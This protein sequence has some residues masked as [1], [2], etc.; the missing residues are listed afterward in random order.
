MLL[1]LWSF[2]VNNED[3]PAGLFEGD[4]ENN[5]QKLGS[6]NPSKEP[7]VWQVVDFP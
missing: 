4:S 7:L 1:V 5:K 2:P 6:S 3:V